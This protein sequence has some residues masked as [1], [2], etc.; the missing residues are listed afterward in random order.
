MQLNTCRYKYIDFEQQYITI[1]L[2]RHSSIV[3]LNVTHLLFNLTKVNTE[4]L[5]VLN[6]WWWFES[7]G[8]NSV[9]VYGQHIEIVTDMVSIIIIVWGFFSI[10]LICLHYLP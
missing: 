7:A 9:E 2:V 8:V 4:T 5:R 3:F 1:V 6:Y 10:F